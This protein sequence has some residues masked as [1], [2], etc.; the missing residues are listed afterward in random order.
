MTDLWESKT[1]KPMLIGAEGE[2]FDSEDFLY[3][4]KLDG[5]RCIAYLDKDRTILKNKRNVLMLPKVPELSEIHRNVNVRCIL[6]GELAVIKDGKGKLYRFLSICISVDIVRMILL[7]VMIF[8]FFGFTFQNA[9][10]KADKPTIRGFFC[11]EIFSFCDLCVFLLAAG[12]TVFVISG[13]HFIILRFDFLWIYK[14]E[15]KTK[16]YGYFTM[17][18]SHFAVL[19]I[20][21]LSPENQFRGHKNRACI[22]GTQAPL[23]EKGRT[24]ARV[25]ICPISQN[26]IKAIFVSS[27][28]NAY[29]A[30]NIYF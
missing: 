3:E 6:D 16:A 28:L 25:P 29:Q 2:P 1:V 21:V 13:F 23:P 5:E 15:I 20:G 24:K 19:S 17:K 4:L 14:V 7:I 18:Q 9:V 22:H 26:E 11:D 12:F 8:V 27:A 30:S 10:S